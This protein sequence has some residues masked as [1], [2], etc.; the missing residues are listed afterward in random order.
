MATIATSTKVKWNE[1]E[2]VGIPSK[3][4]RSVGNGL[5]RTFLCRGQYSIFTSMMFDD[6]SGFADA[7]HDEVIA[8]AVID[9]Y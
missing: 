1:I 3:E 7:D 8:W 9:G 5:P 4:L 6:G 2:K